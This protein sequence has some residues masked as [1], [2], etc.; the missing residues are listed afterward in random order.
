ML[1]QETKNRPWPIFEANMDRFT[2]LTKSIV[3][4]PLLPGLPGPEPFKSMHYCPVDVQLVY[5]SMTMNMIN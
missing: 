4:P 1:P 3:R 5:D 2:D